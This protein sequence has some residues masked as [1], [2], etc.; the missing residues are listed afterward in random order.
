M[1]VNW[2]GAFALTQLVEMPL[3]VYAM[4][5]THTLSNRLLVGFGASALTH[6]VVW[7]VF[8]RLG[9]FDSHVEMVAWAELFAVVT[10]ALYLSWCR[11]SRPWLWALVANMGSFGVG[12]LL[13]WLR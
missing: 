3:Y 9:W 6:P 2:L 8:P 12:V 7:F 13:I 4:R 5:R 1:I 11:A 10:E